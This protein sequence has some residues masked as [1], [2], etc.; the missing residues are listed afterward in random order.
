VGHGR[1]VRVAHDAPSRVLV[2]AFGGRGVVGADLE[3]ARSV[4]QVWRVTAGVVHKIRQVF[5][6][7]T[8]RVE[9]KGRGLGAEHQATIGV[10][11]VV[12]DGVGLRGGVVK[13]GQDR[14]PNVVD[15]DGVRAAVKPGLD[16]LAVPVVVG[17]A[18][19]AERD[20]VFGLVALAEDN[21]VAHA[22]VGV[23]LVVEAGVVGDRIALAVARVGVFGIVG[24]AVGGDE[25]GVGVGDQNALEFMGRGRAG[26]VAEVIGVVADPIL[27]RGIPLLGDDRL[28]VAGQ[29]VGSA[30]VIVVVGHLADIGPRGAVVLRKRQRLYV[31]DRIVGELALLV[32][33]AGRSGLVHDLGDPATDAGLGPLGY[34]DRGPG[35]L[36]P[37]VEA[38]LGMIGLI[39]VEELA[40]RAVLPGEDKE[41]VLG[42]VDEGVL[43]AVAGRIAAALL[44]VEPHGLFGPEAGH[45]VLLTAQQYGQFVGIGPTGTEAG[46]HRGLAAGVGQPSHAPEASGGAAGARDGGHVHQAVTRR[47]RAP[48][49]TAGPEAPTTTSG[50][51]AA[52]T[53]T[54]T[55]QRV[56]AGRKRIETLNDEIVHSVTPVLRVFVPVEGPEIAGLPLRVHDIPDFDDAAGHRRYGFVVNQ[57]HDRPEDRCFGRLG[58]EPG[59]IEFEDPL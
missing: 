46:V 36:D 55:A 34:L 39:G 58:K 42:V 16:G 41:V 3:Q 10:V 28:Q 20:G 27:G 49:T 52:T 15:I 32:R 57:A 26:V 29:A 4:A 14:L 6:V 22:A 40:A 18:V 21:A 25:G 50:P 19:G 7:V 23:V 45:H 51:A 43:G 5:V 11:A 2:N 44:G 17:A 35:G 24:I 8:A 48:T 38:A 53:S 47:S 33:L 12:G 30:A 56:W 37:T 1:L 13:V 31:V 9:H 59:M 54:T